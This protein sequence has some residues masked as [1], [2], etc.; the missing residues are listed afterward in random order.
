[1]VKISAEIKIRV[2]ISLADLSKRHKK[3]THHRRVRTST[4]TDFDVLFACMCH[5]CCVN[6]EKIQLINID[7]RMIR[8]IV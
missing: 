7:T 4:R 1:M 6:T 3:I 5:C 2:F 8:R